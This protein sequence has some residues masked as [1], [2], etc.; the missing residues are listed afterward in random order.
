QEQRTL[1]G[2]G[3]AIGNFT[4]RGWASAGSNEQ[5]HNVWRASGTYVTGAHSLKVGYQAA[6]QVQKNFQNAL[7]QVRYV[8]NAAAAPVKADGTRDPNPIQVELR[9]APFWQSNRTRFDAI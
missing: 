4:Y 1:A 2:G 3:L 7:S 8:F 6:F 5:L 9:D